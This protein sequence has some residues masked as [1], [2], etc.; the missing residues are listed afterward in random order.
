ML[1]PKL[2]EAGAVAKRQPQIPQQHMVWWK[3]QCRYRGLPVK[4]T[5]LELQSR[6]RNHGEK[7]LGGVS[8]MAYEMLAKEYEANIQD[9][10][11]EAR[12]RDDY[13]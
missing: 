1:T 10:G 8:K 9:E 7:G 4:G 11:E 2:T 13:S 6:I 12:K 5:E 3:A